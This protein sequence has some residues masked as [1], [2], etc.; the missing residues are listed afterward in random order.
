[1]ERRTLLRAAALGAL[2]AGGSLPRPALAQA[3]PT[4]PLRMV[5]PWPAGQAT[6]IMGRL[7]AETL[8][9]SL[10]QPVVPENRPGAGG[11]IGTDHVAKAAPDGYTLLAGSS[12]PVSVAP[13][14]QRVPFDPERDLLPVAMAGNSPYLLVIRNGFPANNMAEF[15]RVV[16]ANPGR[17]SFASSGT[18]ATAHLVAEA[19]NR[20]LGL[21]VTHVPFT[22]SAAGTAAVVGG[23]VDYVVET[24]AATQPVIRGNNLRALG[25]SL[26]NGSTL[27]PDV[28]PMSRVPGLE[29]LDLGAWLGVMVPARTPAPIISRLASAVREGMQNP[30]LVQRMASAGVEPTYKD[31]DGMAAHLR[32]QRTVF[33][34]VIQRAN[35]RID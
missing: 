10:G 32:D 4:R 27:A 15:I 9:Q 35:I 25:I 13:L 7:I 14:L 21:D 19:I 5:I 29:G 17:Y 6:D 3:Y 12:G 22:G 34:D 20:R 2:A 16:R 30:A 33:S 18:G 28:P 1:M 8:A 26:L 24:L 11:V 31:T 23:H